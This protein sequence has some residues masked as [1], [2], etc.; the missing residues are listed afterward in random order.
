MKT[1]FQKNT[2]FS[3]LLCTTLASTIILSFVL[4][5]SLQRIASEHPRQ[6][7]ATV[8]FHE[9]LASNSLDQLA[10]MTI[11]GAP[12]RILTPREASTQDNRC[13]APLLQAVDAASMEEDSDRTAFPKRLDA[14]KASYGITVRMIDGTYYA[15]ARKESHYVILPPFAEPLSSLAIG[16][17]VLIIVTISVVVIANVWLIRRLTRPFA[18]LNTAVRNI[19]QE[20]LSYRI[21]LAATYGE[22]HT[23]ATGF[24]TMTDRLARLYDARKAML[25]AIAHEL[26]TPL[27]RLKVRKDLIPDDILQKAVRK[28]IND[29]EQILD[30]IMYTERNKAGAVQPKTELISL[31]GPIDEIVQEFTSPDREVIVDWQTKQQ[32]CLLPRMMFT[33]LLRNLVDNA[34]RHG[35]SPSVTVRLS[36]KGGSELHIQVIDQGCGI[37][38]EYIP[39]MT[40]PFW[41]ADPARQRETGGYGLGLYVCRSIVDSLNGTLS[42]DSTLGTGTTISLVLPN[43]ICE[44]ELSASE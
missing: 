32:T 25:L 16:L 2:V 5:F 15:A 35:K 38:R 19:E 14:L 29:I 31:D 30:A 26:R 21:P 18:V 40:D 27:A 4:I 39:L 37:A 43:V 24:N 9:L 36:D 13:L 28:D 34:F 10:A 12:I 23:L 44:K 33:L 8:L 1:F 41:R 3:A 7:L 20:N 11:N 17:I 6:Y 42:I 22:Y